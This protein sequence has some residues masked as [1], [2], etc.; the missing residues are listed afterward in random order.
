MKNRLK[1]LERH[2]K[3]NAWKKCTKYLAERLFEFWKAHAV[4]LDLQTD[5]GFV[6]FPS[7]VD[8][9]FKFHHVLLLLR[10]TYAVKIYAQLVKKM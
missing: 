4:T 9:N 1:S 3:E 5:F 7:V 8:K 6:A 10:C 2:K